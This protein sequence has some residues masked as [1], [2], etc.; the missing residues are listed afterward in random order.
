MIRRSEF[1]DVDLAEVADLS[2][3]GTWV[4]EAV[5]EI[6]HGLV[7]AWSLLNMMSKGH[8]EKMTP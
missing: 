7:E 8:E 5:H 1:N 3:H 6:I 4:D 2:E